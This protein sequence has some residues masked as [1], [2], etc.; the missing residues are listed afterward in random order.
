MSLDRIGSC[1]KCSLDGLYKKDHNDGE[2]KV[3]QGE[4]GVGERKEG[5]KEELELLGGI[6]RAVVNTD[7]HT[8][9]TPSWPIS[10]SSILSSQE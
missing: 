8:Q 2:R 3:R 10:L 1:F 9:H 6:L 4:K 5:K 7:T